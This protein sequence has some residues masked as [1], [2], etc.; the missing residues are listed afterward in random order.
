MFKGE[1]G[2][3]FSYSGL[4]TAVINYIHTKEM[5]SEAWSR[6][7]VAASFQHAA[8]DILVER[9]VEAA[10]EEGVGVVTAGGGVIANGYLRERLASAC[11]PPG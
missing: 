11:G 5:K 1:G 2:Y 9:T 6:A 10:K 3:R 8:L 7:D 4:K